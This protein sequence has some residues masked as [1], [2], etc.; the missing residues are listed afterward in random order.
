MSWRRS[1]PTTKRPDLLPLFDAKIRYCYTDCVGA[2]VPPTKNRRKRDY[3]LEWLKALQHDL[4]RQYEQWQE[5]AA[6]APCPKISP[7]RALDTI[8]WELGNR[9]N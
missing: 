5:M 1:P 3:R 2:P 6:N 8:G 9:K 4:D 7:L